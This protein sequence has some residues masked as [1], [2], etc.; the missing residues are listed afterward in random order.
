M[1]CHD[2][3]TLDLCSECLDA[4]ITPKRRPGLEALHTPNHDM[5]KVYRVLFGR[6]V[7][8]TERSAK[9]ALKT[10]WTT[11]SDL[12]AEKQLLPGCVCC[13]NI[14]I[15][16]CWYCIDCIGE[17]PQSPFLSPCSSEYFV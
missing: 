11:I 7:A 16:P 2:N 12:E 4:V 6:D 5:L 8:R 15:L 9:E 3:N 13:W 17:F 1:D 10:A 14:V